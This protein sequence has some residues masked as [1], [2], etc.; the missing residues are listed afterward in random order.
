VGGAVG[1]RLGE[2]EVG[3]DRAVRGPRAL[4]A[5]GCTARPVRGLPSVALAVNSHGIVHID[6]RVRQRERVVL[7]RFR[8]AARGVDHA[9]GVL[10]VLRALFAASAA[11]RVGR[12][13]E[14]VGGVLERVGFLLGAV[15]HRLEGLGLGEPHRRVE[16]VGRVGEGRFRPLE[17]APGG[18]PLPVLVVGHRLGERRPALG[19]ALDARPVALQRRLVA[20]D[21][22]D[23]PLDRVDVDRFRQVVGRPGM[24]DHP[25]VVDDEHRPPGEPFARFGLAVDAVGARR[26]TVDIAQKRHPQT[27]PLGEGLVAVRAVGR[28]GKDRDVPLHR[29]QVQAVQVRRLHR[30]RGVEIRRVEGED[31]DPLAQVRTEV[32]PLAL[33]VDV[34]GKFHRRRLGAL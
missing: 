28:D 2:R 9:F 3:L 14:P 34:A 6:P 16:V 20:A 17:P 11:Q 15:G 7:G 4:A 5:R 13:A 1:R 23:R 29:E 33:P 32:D 21:V 27:V 8:Q 24:L 30:A 10:A 18:H 12:L 26:P 31:D 19:V 25:A 22:A